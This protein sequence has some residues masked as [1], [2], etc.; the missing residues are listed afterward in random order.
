MA[1]KMDM[2]KAYDW[3][4]WGF[5]KAVME[6]LGFHIIWI[7]WIMACMTL[8]TYSFLV[9]GSPQGKVVPSRGIRQGDPLSPN[10][11]IFCTKVLSGLCRKAQNNGWLPRV[12][13]SRHSPA[14]NHLLF[15]DD[16]IFSVNQMNLVVKLSRGSY[17]SIKRHW[18]SQ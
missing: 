10:L 4:E 6:R 8:V 14:I 11:F 9:N 16:T 15:A 7:N 12:K 1:F 18:A 2:S 3:I 5:L 17:R 13:V